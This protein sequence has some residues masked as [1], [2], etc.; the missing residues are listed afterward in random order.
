MKT[1]CDKCKSTN[2]TKAG[3]KQ[4]SNEKVQKYKCN[5]CKKFFTGMEKFHRLD[6]DTKERILKIYQRQKDQR[7]VARILNINLAT[8]Q[9]HLKNLVFSYSKI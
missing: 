8:V 9:Y 4:L 7:E 5:Q 1:Q 6:D 2:T 3:F